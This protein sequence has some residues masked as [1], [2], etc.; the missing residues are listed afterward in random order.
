M[1]SIYTRNMHRS[2][3]LNG[4]RWPLLILPLV[5]RSQRDSYGFPE[6]AVLPNPPDSDTS[7]VEILIGTMFN[8][9]DGERRTFDSVDALLDAGW[10]VD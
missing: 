6:C 3:I 7:S 4:N 8:F 1:D 9:R 10:E 5:N 2:M